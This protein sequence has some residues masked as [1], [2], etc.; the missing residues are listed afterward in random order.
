[1]TDRDTAPQGFGTL[2]DDLVTAFGL[3]SRLPVPT[4]RFSG[5]ESVWAWPIVGLVV[6]ALSVATALAAL[7][8]GLPAPLAAAAVMAVSALATGA[9]HDDGLADT[10]DGLFGGWTRERRLEIMKDSHI[11]SYGVLALLIVGLARWSALGA[12]LSLGHWYALP[13]A[14]ALSRAPMAVLMALLPN[15]RQGGLSAN[16]GRPPKGRVLICCGVALT[17]A[18]ATG[19]SGVVAMTV[20]VATAT[21]VI[22]LIAK[23]RIGGQTGDILGATQNLGELAAL[24]AALAHLS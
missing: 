7:H 15:A 9:M 6:S 24:C 20:S 13:A 18:A 12:L 4:R 5:A 14:A 22:G 21:A 11:G 8:M 17:I 19:C 23:S 3:L 16:T 2:L 10:F 1:M